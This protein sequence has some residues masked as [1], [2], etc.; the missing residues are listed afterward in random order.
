MTSHYIALGIA[1]IAGGLCGLL[2][3]GTCL[4]AV[5]IAAVSAWGNG[6]H[7]YNNKLNTQDRAKPVA[8]KITKIES[9]IQSVFT[10]I[11]EHEAEPYL[12]WRHEDEN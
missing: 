6:V 9:A 11:S 12:I 7:E 8:A 3:A 1:I 10:Y 2:T 5:A 4:P